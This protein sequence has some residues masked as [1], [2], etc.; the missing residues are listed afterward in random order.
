MVCSLE[1]WFIR[2]QIPLKHCLSFT[3]Y[4][5]HSQTAAV[6]QPIRAHPLSHTRRL[7]R[8][9]VPGRLSTLFLRTTT[10]FVLLSAGVLHSCGH[11]VSG[12]H[13]W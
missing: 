5:L 2:H 9:S 7:Q 13:I 8:R 1:I 11:V 12:L 10:V 4:D 3:V 6:Q